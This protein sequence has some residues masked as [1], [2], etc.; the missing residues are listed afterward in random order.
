MGSPSDTLPSTSI[1]NS[2]LG[3]WSRARCAEI[4]CST[5]SSCSLVSSRPTII[6]LSP[7]LSR[8][9]PSVVRI[10]C[11][12]SKKTTVRLVIRCSAIQLTRSFDLRGGNPRN[13]NSLALTPAAARIV[14]TAL[15]PGIATTMCPSSRAILTRCRPGSDTSGV[16]ASETRAIEAPSPR[17][18]RSESAFLVSLCSC[19]LVVGVAIE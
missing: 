16:P 12:A 11:G 7:N 13:R 5:N 2:P 14:V 6:G 10:R 18:R 3:C 4:G 15:G 8:I 19:R 17:R 9:R 1:V